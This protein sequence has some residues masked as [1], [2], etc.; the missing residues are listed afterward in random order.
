MASLNKMIKTLTAMAN[1]SPGSTGYVC[2]G[3]ADNERDAQRVVDIYGIK[4]AEY[5][6]FKITGIYH[7]AENLQ[8]DL[9]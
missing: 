5:K 3:G 8:G 2:V 7:E 4:P 1:N 6:G 9:A